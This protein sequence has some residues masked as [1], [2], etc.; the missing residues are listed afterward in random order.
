MNDRPDYLKPLNPQQLEAAEK[1]DGPVLVLAGA[2]SGKTRVIT[3]RIAY[4][5]AYHGVP[6]Y[7]ILAMTFTNKAAK[8]MKTRVESILGLVQPELTISTFHSFC[9]RFLR[10][11]IDYLGRDSNFVI[12][13]TQD[14][15]KVLREL[16]K[17]LKLSPKEYPPGLLRQKISRRKNQM[18]DSTF[19]DADLEQKLFEGYQAELLAQNA[20]DFDDLLLLTNEI[21]ETNED[22]RERYRKRFEQI[23]VDEYQDTNRVQ[24]KLLTYLCRENPNLCVVGDEDQSI[25]S[26]RGADIRNILDFE[27]HFPNAVTIKLEQNYRS[28]KHILE[29][30]N[31]VIA[32]N[33]QRKEKKLWSDGQPGPPPSVRTYGSGRQE[34]ESI[35]RT[36]K[37]NGGAFRDVAVLFRANYLSRSLEEAFRREGIP[38]QL[39][40]GLKFYDRKEI[41]DVL[42]Y[43]RC[44]VNDRDWTSFSRAVNTPSR[45][46]GARSLDLLRFYF[47]TSQSIE[48]A[49]Q[50]AL[51]ERALSGRAKN[52]VRFFLEMLREYRDQ[53][54]DES[55]SQWLNLL[56]QHIEYRE[57]LR[58]E[59]ALSHEKREDNLN[60]LLA[61]MREAEKQG[62]NNVAAFLDFSSLVS[63]QDQMDEVADKVSLMT[64]HASKGLEYRQVYVVGLEEGVFPNKR[65]LEENEGAIE[66]ERRLFYVSITRAM[67]RLYLSYSKTR[68]TYGSVISNEP[69]RFL[70]GLLPEFSQRKPIQAVTPGTNTASESYRIGEKVR[71]PYF[72][73][74]TLVAMSPKGHDARITI[75]FP[76]CGTRVFLKSKAPIEKI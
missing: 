57:A 45:G 3:S 14:Q 75:R 11:E 30:A 26:W 72:G 53:M 61:S 56:I 6:P 67:E 37:M 24:F 43:M 41:K 12:F 1:I 31:Q 54:S 52:G 19:L 74:G 29:L 69:S 17:R 18:R 34:A 16:L 36:I 63:D 42:S 13:D 40:G 48:K 10:I 21:L 73:I 60:E 32:K 2:G 20:L 70:Q 58:R 68:M 15:D 50:Q 62:I 65:A 9:A 47:D 59:D 76:S 39:I 64:V 38:Y 23:L 51:D 28:T 5:I 55:P 71:H 22:C 25:Y 46:I 8:E 44:M 7:R 27:R 66:E 33:T 35:T 49:M 4:L